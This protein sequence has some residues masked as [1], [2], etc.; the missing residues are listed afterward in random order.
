LF[1]ALLPFLAGLLLLLALLFP[2]LLAILAGLAR[3]LLLTALFFRALLTPILVGLAGLLSFLFTL[4][5]ALLALGLIL[6]ASLFAATAST[7]S[8]GEAARP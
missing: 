7:L 8:V 2:A 4:L 6:L 1:P 5:L 3:L